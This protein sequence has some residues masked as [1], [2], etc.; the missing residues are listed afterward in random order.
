MAEVLLRHRLTALGVDARVHSAGL[1]VPGLPAHDDTARA[2]AAM[3]HDLAAHRSRRMTADMVG[4]SD[5]V[6]GLARAHV[7]EAVLLA[8]GAWPRCY[9]VKEAVRRAGIVGPRAPGQA[10]PA[11][12]AALHAGRRREDLVG[13]SA[14]DDV[15]DPYGRGL[16]TSERTA[17]ELDALVGELVE[18]GWARTSRGDAA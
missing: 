15:D 14:A 16:G 1:F 4:E 5:L 18:L 2:M 13:A 11:W 8:P 6:L 7:R 17:A 9:T 10:F 3:G 12:V